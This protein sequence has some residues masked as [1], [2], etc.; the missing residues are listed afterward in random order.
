MNKKKLLAVLCMVFVTVSTMGFFGYNVP[1]TFTDS[2]FNDEIIITDGTDPH[3]IKAIQEAGGDGQLRVAVDADDKIVLVTDYANVDTDYDLTGTPSLGSS[4]LVGDADGDSTVGFSWAADDIALLSITNGIW[5]QIDD[6]VYFNDG[7]SL[8]FGISGDVN[9]SWE[10]GTGDDILQW[11]FQET[12]GNALAGVAIG[13][14]TMSTE[15]ESGQSLENTFDDRTEPFIA[16]FND[17]AD[18]YSVWGAGD[19]NP[20]ITVGGN[21]TSFSI[22]DLALNMPIT[23]TEDSGAIAVMNMSVSA[24]PAAGTEES[25]SVQV[26]SNNVAT[27]YAQADSSGGIKARG[28]KREVVELY[29][30]ILNDTSTPHALTVAECMDTVITTQ[31]WNGTDD[32]TFNLPN[33]SAYDGSAGILRVRFRDKIGMQDGDTD[34]YVDPDASTQIVIDEV[35]TGTDGDRMKCDN[36]DIWDTITC[37]STWTTGLGG[38]WHCITDTGTWTDAGS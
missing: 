11:Y 17:T 13:D 3:L 4:L 20:S 8:A 26:D 16:L 14:Y 34:I 2:T 25:Y 28:F 19:D 10:T 33:I 30:A 35:I 32:I 21:A 7:K 23:H 24:T 22:P 6:G 18:S 15:M 1:T 38:V 9:I 29:P 27:Y 31:G 12:D 5:I 37:E 36:S